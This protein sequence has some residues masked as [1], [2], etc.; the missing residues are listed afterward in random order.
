MFTRRFQRGGHTR[1]FAV[2]RTDG[3]VVREENDRG[4]VRE[5]VTRNWRRIEAE[6]AIFD[7]K[8]DRLIRTGWQERT[9]HPSIH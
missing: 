3:W 8:A 9:E 7:V 1:S 2:Y 6:M 4:I 5:I